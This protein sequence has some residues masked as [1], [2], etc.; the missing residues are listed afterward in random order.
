MTLQQATEDQQQKTQEHLR[1]CAAAAR[2]QDAY[3]AHLESIASELT[4]GMKQLGAGASNLLEYVGGR[5]EQGGLNSEY[6]KML[7]DRVANGGAVHWTD[8][9]GSKHGCTWSEADID[10]WTI[11]RPAVWE[12]R[13]VSLNE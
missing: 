8:V 13:A 3:V 4:R 2:T 6:Y 12:Y 1:K 5:Y 10:T 11:E 9:R 7:L